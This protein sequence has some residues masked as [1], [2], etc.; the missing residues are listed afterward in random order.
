MKL[1][2]IL[3]IWVLL[4]ACGSLVAQSPTERAKRRAERRAESKVNSKVDRSVDKAVDDVFGSIFGKKK[5]KKTEDSE[6]TEATDQG[7]E[8]AETAMLQNMGLLGGNWEPYTNPATFSLDMEMK[9]TDKRGRTEESTIRMAVTEN[10]FATH[11]TDPDKGTEMRMILDTQT[12]KVIMITTE[13]PNTD[14]EKTQAMRMRMPG[15]SKA[16]E[17]AVVNQDITVNKTGE[18][19]TIDGYDCEKI[20]ITDNETGDVTTSWVTKDIEFKVEDIAATFGGMVKGKNP[21]M[22]ALGNEYPGFPIQTTHTDG[23][24]TLFM[25]F[26]NIKTGDATDQG[27]LDT[28]DIPIQDIGF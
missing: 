15:L 11:L 14:K 24:E 12:G 18:R 4:L 26:R 9:Q 6:N 13:H 10:N 8:A 2:T 7:D 20:I 28:G 23:E 21:A 16:I 3:S 22:E 1:R 17:E 19:K 25:H 27:L 5:K